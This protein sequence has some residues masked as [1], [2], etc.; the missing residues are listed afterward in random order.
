VKGAARRALILAAGAGKRMRRA[1]G[2]AELSAE[3]A[4]AALAGQKA[5]MPVAGR[6]FL[7]YLADA[8]AAADVRE[9]GLVIAASS[10]PASQDVHLNQSVDVT[11]IVQQ[12]PLG[13]ADAV[14]S[15]RDWAKDDP[16]LVL[17]GDNLYPAAAIGAVASASGPALAGFDR[18]DLVATSNVPA[19]RINAFAVIERDDDGNLARIIEKPSAADLAGI[20]PPVLVSMNL[21]RFDARIFDAC[22]D[23]APSARGELELPAAVMLARARGV[24]FEVVAAKGPVLDLSSRNDIA[25]VTRRLGAMS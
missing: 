14:L 11:L 17:N 8:L 25:D 4:A 21:W 10:V 1:E 13:T 24:S 9:V 2:G 5:F 15:A 7:G 20:R 3:Q 16:F 6:P 22:R 19:E 23:V 12:H 18:D